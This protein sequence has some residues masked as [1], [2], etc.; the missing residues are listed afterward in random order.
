ME[1]D[2]ETTNAQVKIAVD[3]QTFI[4]ANC[5]G[6]MKY[7][8]GSEKFR[9]TSCKTESRI[10]TGSETVLEYDFSEYSEREKSSVAFEGVALG[11][12]PK[13]RLRNYL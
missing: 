4:C 5:G 11:S 9:C 1:M 10:E 7:D 8:I 13:L 12:L 6:V 2:M 3:T